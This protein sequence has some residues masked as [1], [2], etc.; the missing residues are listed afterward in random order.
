M[1]EAFNLKIA[2]NINDNFVSLKRSFKSY[3]RNY[4]KNKTKNNNNFILMNSWIKELI[5]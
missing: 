2:I 3:L 5:S 4:I 1:K